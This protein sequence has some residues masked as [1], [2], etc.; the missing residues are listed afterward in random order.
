MPSEV[1]RH[2]QQEKSVE[3]PKLEQGMHPSFLNVLMQK[4]N[5]KEKTAGI[6]HRIGVYSAKGGVGKT[7]IAVNIAYAL[8]K[9]RKKVGLLDADIDCPDI[10]FFLGMDDVVAQDYPLKPIIKDNI[11]VVSTAMFLP[12]KEKPIIWRGPMKAKMLCEFFENTD[13]GELDYL[14]IDLPPG[15]SDTPLSLMQLLD[16]D[17]IILVT[18]PQSI[19][20]KN[21]IRAGLM[22]QSMNIHVFGVVETMSGERMYGS[23][24][25][26]KTLKIPILGSIKYDPNFNKWSDHGKVP[27]VEDKQLMETFED[28]VGKFVR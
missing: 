17:G 22:A 24:E 2:E 23:E 8:S 3:A 27:V 26:S 12:N 19:A 1:L 21:A 14:I 6:R 9:L 5:I 18:T 10:T 11:K 15:T 13:W 7:T 25:V 20:A 16:L 4:R 28:I